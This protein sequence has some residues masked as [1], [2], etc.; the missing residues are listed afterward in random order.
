M[1]IFRQFPYTNF[2]EM[3]L[4]WVIQKINEMIENI[5]KINKK[6]DDFIIETEPTIRDE[7]DKWLDEHPE[8]TTTVEDHSLS[9]EKLING[10]MKYVFPQMFGADGT[11]EN[12]DTTA[13][14]EMFDKVTN[15]NC[16][17]I[18]PK[19]FY[20]ISNPI[21]SD[22][23]IVLYNDGTFINK[24]LIVSKTLSTV[25][26][27]VMHKTFN[28]MNP[29]ITG[30]LQGACYDSINNRIIIAYTGNEDTSPAL[31]MAYDPEFNSEIISNVV[32][33]TSHFNDMAF[34]PNT[35]KIY[36][37]ARPTN[38]TIYIIDP[39]TLTVDT[40][41]TI[42][43]GGIIKR[44][45]FDPTTNLYFIHGDDFLKIYDSSFNL[46]YTMPYQISLLASDSGVS[47]GTLLVQGSS[48][49]E[50]QFIFLWSYVYND[51]SMP[52]T[53]LTQFDYVHNKIKRTYKFNSLTGDDEAEGFYIINKTAYITSGLGRRV[54]I[55]KIDL[56]NIFGE[57]SFETHVC[58]ANEN[59]DDYS[60]PGEYH[61]VSNDIA[62]TLVNCP[63]TR[64]F[65]MVVT[66]NGANNYMLQTYT[67]VLGNVYYRYFRQDTRQWYDGG[68]LNTADV[69]NW[70]NQRIGNAML[71]FI[72]YNA[73]AQ[74]WLASG[75]IYQSEQIS[76]ELPVTQSRIVK[77]SASGSC[78]NE[79]Y[80]TDFTVAD[81]YL[82]YRIGSPTA[83]PNT[84]NV[85]I[86]LVTA[87]SS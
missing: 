46:L 85:R 59:V 6:V 18:I 13:F 3:N 52:Y 69:G 71:S 5:F 32:N 27:P 73:G 47:G 25:L 49:Y 1:G 82:K 64:A 57:L 56:E 30:F 55:H 34:N 16:K 72:S 11:G 15:D 84:F 17:V 70:H 76:V 26:S 81:G 53:Y 12:D 86:I 19:G 87:L 80:L 36:A 9:Y 33:P 75:N 79:G 39:T 8:A 61:C 78:A 62:T 14:S 4:D 77:Y 48:V 2:H 20:N 45:S 66:P 42:N 28:V 29:N 68:G 83:T 43:F 37:P 65:R 60:T 41:F 10:T 24:K 67:D 38:D 40:S 21:F 22:D 31:L 7:V 74:N 58:Q 63:T 44:I 50:N 54:T 51:G 35:G 23:S